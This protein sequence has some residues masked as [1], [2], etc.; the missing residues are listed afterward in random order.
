MGRRGKYYSSLSLGVSKRMPGIPGRRY[1][2]MMS[3]LEILPKG[4][5][6]W[7]LLL[8]FLITVGTF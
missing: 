4:R 6:G 2:E 3:L 8:P 1:P 7:H 5:E